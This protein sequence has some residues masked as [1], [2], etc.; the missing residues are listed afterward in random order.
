MRRII[1]IAAAYAPYDEAVNSPADDRLF[2][3][4]D[5]GSV[6]VH[7]WVV[8]ADSARMEGTWLEMADIPQDG[9]E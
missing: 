2:A 1:Q 4:C 6:W 3:L 5:D 7:R 8:Y 9:E